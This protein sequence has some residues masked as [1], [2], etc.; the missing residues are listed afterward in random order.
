MEG[1]PRYER[2]KAVIRPIREKEME[3]DGRADAEDF[4]TNQEKLDR[5]IDLHQTINR[6]LGRFLVLVGAAEGAAPQDS[7]HHYVS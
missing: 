6:G 3:A 1:D 7:L 2:L 4:E 5:Q